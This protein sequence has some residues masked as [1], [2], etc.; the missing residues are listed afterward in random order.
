MEDEAGQ[1][2]SAG[3]RHIIE[4][5]R[6][7]KLLDETSARVI[8]LVAPAGYG[9]TTLARQWLTR[10]SHA[11][12]QGSAS[13]GDVAALALGIAEA[14]EPLVSG[15]G[16][17]L[18][19]WLPTSREPQEEIDLIEQFLSED[20]ADWPDDAFFVVDD[21]HLLSSAPTEELIR[22]LFVTS[23]PRLMLTSRKRPA[24]SSARVLLSGNFFELGQSSLAMKTQE[25]NAV[26][27]PGNTDAVSGLVALADGWP[28]VIGLAALSPNAITLE[29]GFPDELHDYF[30][31]ELFASLPADTQKGLCKLAL[32]PVITRATAGA[33]LGEAAERV[34]EEAKSAGMFV[35]QRAQELSL[36]PLLRSFLL[37]KLAAAPR[38]DVSAAVTTASKHLLEVKAW[39]EAFALILE[40]K[41]EQNSLD[42]LL[43]R[44]IVPLTRLGRLATVREWLDFAREQGIASPYVDLA[45]AELAFRQG[46]QE[47]G[48][49]L[50][51]AAAS[52]LEPD[53][54]LQSLAHYRAGQSRYFADDSEGAL[55]HFEAAQSSAKTP[56]DEREALWG[57]FIVAVEL[58]RQETFELF[59]QLQARGM[60]DRDAAVRL[61]CARLMLALFAGGSIPS[62]AEVASLSVL[63]GDASD[64]LVRSALFR[65][66]A[67]VLV[68]G[69][70]YESAL[71]AVANALD[72][73]ERFHLDF[74]RPHSLVSRATAYIG[75]RRF[76]DA[77]ASLQ[78]IG[79][80]AQHMNDPYL[81]ANVDIL[82]CRLLLNEGSPGAALHAASGNWSRGPTAVRKMEFEVT[83]AIALACAGSPT[84]AL[85]VLEEVDGISRALEPQ[86]L[87]QWA[88]C[89]CLLAMEADEAEEAVVA[90]YDATFQSGGH[91]AFV[92]ANRLHPNILAILARDARRHEALAEVLARSN[93]HGRAAA[94]GIASESSAGPTHASLTPRENEV[95]A[96][97]A[98][99]RTNR[100]IAHALFISEPTVKVHVRNI[101][102]KLGAR[103]RVEAAIQAVRMRPLQA[104]AADDPGANQPS[105]DPPG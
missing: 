9:K 52:S 41:L 53:D 19:E 15:A 13:S 83:K 20:F 84:S 100:E 42:E 36:H 5:P 43:A 93:D 39:D 67:A 25:A 7:T 97:L 34:I 105:S 89:I 64:P 37:D 92:F 30:A 85:K 28:A 102:R 11:W 78:E 88:R 96:L 68:F 76:A 48:G 61:E 8:M 74:V 77:A 56:T 4:R 22:R 99:G 18:R 72:E 16:R 45:D 3:R 103:T 47:R 44:A 90:A 65:A 31:E 98:A 35:V 49:A 58:E 32:V 79:V 51:R 33:L 21:Y 57:R 86:L 82:R 91:D 54:P 38:T 10:R 63:A 73:A 81:A 94:E 2:I 29:E 26:M 59:S 66:L 27:A 69:A 75:L 62:R 12:Y 1:E 50:A 40:F 17:R 46:R 104:S 23:G 24:W 71:E 70:H 87:Y 60:Q 55:L 101:L 80:A 14:V 95:Y 6:L